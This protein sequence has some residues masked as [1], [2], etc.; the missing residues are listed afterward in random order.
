MHF[1]VIDRAPPANPGQAFSGVPVV[2]PGGPRYPEAG[3]M[4]IFLVEVDRESGMPT[5]GD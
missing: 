4:L 1:L 5:A 2:W 3:L